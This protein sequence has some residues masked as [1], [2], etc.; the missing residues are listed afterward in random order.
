MESV[1]FGGGSHPFSWAIFLIHST[2]CK[3]DD[4]NGFEGNSETGAS[5][6]GEEYLLILWHLIFSEGAEIRMLNILVLDYGA[7]I[8]ITS[9]PNKPEP[10]EQ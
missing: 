3:T 8:S 2:S 4:K 6:F 1:G 9:V 5:S 10:N 7:A